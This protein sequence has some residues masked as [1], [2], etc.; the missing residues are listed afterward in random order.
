MKLEQEANEP[1]HPFMPRISQSSKRI[2][3]SRKSFSYEYG[4]TQTQ[5]DKLYLEG[6]ENS[7]KDKR[8]LQGDETDFMKAAHEYSF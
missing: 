8:D 1:E 4:N 3:E 6:L 7:K 2:A 5:W